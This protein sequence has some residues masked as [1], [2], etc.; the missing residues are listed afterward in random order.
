AFSGI[1]RLPEVELVADEARSFLTRDTRSYAVITMSLI[2]T[3]AATGAGAYALSEN[4]LYTAEAWLR[5]TDRLGPTGI[6]T[7]SRWYKPGAPGETARMIALAMEVLWRRGVD[8]PRRHLIVLQEGRSASLLLSPS[9][10]SEAD[11]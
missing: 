8:D 6:F 4:G 9:P 3:W 2:D 10:F 11:L 1:G 7:V 5:I